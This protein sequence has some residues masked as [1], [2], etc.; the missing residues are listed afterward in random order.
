M[1][2]ILIK[3]LNLKSV[4]MEVGKVV[5]KRNKLKDYFGINSYV[6]E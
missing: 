3:L 2:D 5:Y 6:Q 4:M 1:Y